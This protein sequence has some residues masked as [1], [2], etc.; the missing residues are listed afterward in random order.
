MSEP[1]RLEDVKRLTLDPS[2]T[3]VLK[4]KHG[5][6]THEALDALQDQLSAIFPGHRT[7]VLT[8]GTDLEVIEGERSA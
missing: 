8:P 6:L 7:V 2:D 5:P 4:I 1:I 3:L